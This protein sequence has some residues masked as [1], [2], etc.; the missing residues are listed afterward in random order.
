MPPHSNLAVERAESKKAVAANAG[1]AFEVVR[2]ASIVGQTSMEFI[3]N[4]PKTALRRDA[5]C[6]RPAFRSATGG[7]F[8]G[9]TE[10]KR[11]LWPHRLTTFNV[12]TELP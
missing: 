12:T 5:R 10:S 7:R 3:F 2:V 8:G 9:F 4:W 1:G 6:Q 11:A